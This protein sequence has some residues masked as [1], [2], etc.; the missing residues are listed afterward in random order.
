VLKPPVALTIAGSDSSGGAGIQADLKTFHALGVYGASAITA[1]TAQSTVGVS[2][3][4]PV[5]AAFVALQIDTTVA[6]IPPDAVKTGMLAEAAIVDVVSEAAVRHRFA[7]F[8]VDPVMVATTGARLLSDDAVDRVRERLLPLATLVTPNAP[9][10]AVLLGRAV[11]TPADQEAA[12][13]ALV[14]ELG[15]RAALVKGGDLA[16]ETLTDA[17]C[18]AGEGGRA[19]R[20]HLFRD[21]RIETTSTHGSGCALASAIAAWLARGETL[22]AAVAKARAWVRRGIETAPS[23]GRGRGPLDL[24]PRD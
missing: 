8:V 1:L 24:F 7:A 2:G 22:A 18:E 20:V 9:E 12:A 13:R 19:P 21:R 11:E 6:D 14:L 5:D 4:V 23:L 10:A 16:G 3:I 17:Y 15:A